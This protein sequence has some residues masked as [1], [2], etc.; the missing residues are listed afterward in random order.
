MDSNLMLNNCEISLTK[1][2][3]EYSSWIFHLPLPKIQKVN[4]SFPALP[5][6]EILVDLWHFHNNS[7]CYWEILTGISRNLCDADI[8]HFTT[9]ASTKA[10][11]STFAE[12]CRAND[13]LHDWTHGNTF[14]NSQIPTHKT[15]CPRAFIVMTN[16]IQI[17]AP[18][19][20][21]RSSRDVT[22]TRPA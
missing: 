3:G 21:C 13:E 16:V 8:L 11:H 12:N 15:S 6:L 20:F 9:A 17:F 18:L 7:E 2:C 22:P 4:M 14:F 19:N 10:V 5:E 1:P